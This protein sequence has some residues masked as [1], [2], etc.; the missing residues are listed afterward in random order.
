MNDELSNESEWMYESTH[1]WLINFN[2]RNYLVN[3]WNRVDKYYCIVWMI[4]WMYE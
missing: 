2:D 1:N 3:E 4:E